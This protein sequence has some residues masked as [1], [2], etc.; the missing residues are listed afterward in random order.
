MAPLRRGTEDTRQLVATDNMDENRR[1][2]TDW[3][4]SY[5]GPTAVYEAATFSWLGRRTRAA[6][7]R[8]ELSYWL[9]DEAQSGLD[10]RLA[11]IQ[12]ALLTLVMITVRNTSLWGR[13]LGDIST[14]LDVWTC[15][16]FSPSFYSTN[17]HLC[18]SSTLHVQRLWRN[19]V[20]S[21]G[22]GAPSFVRTEDAFTQD[23]LLWYRSSHETHR[24]HT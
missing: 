14:D 18:Q 23:V 15:T 13:C 5:W 11:L 20:D 10:N 9:S 24:S 12:K 17:A 4:R 2:W 8:G 22:C 3:M 1:T 7:T 21:F 19:I 16:F 6:L